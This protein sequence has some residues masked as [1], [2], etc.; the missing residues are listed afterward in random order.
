M[1]GR[2]RRNPRLVAI[3]PSILHVPSLDFVAQRDS[4]CDHKTDGPYDTPDNRR[5]GCWDRVACTHTSQDFASVDNED[6]SIARAF[7][8]YRDEGPFRCERIW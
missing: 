5:E 4:P 3:V 7:Q 2:L 1:N 6:T 8:P